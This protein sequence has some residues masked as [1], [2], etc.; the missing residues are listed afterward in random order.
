MKRNVEIFQNKMKFIGKQNWTELYKC[1]KLFGK[2]TGKFTGKTN[3]CRIII[4]LSKE[5]LIIII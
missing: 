2:F 5:V 3:R 4:E 1:N